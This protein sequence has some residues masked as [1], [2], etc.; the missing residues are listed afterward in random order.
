ME[1]VEDF[2]CEAK[3][4]H[5]SSY[6]IFFIFQFSSFFFTFSFSFS[7][8]FIFFVFSIFSVFFIFSLFHFFHFFIFFVFFFFS[9]FFF[10]FSFSFL[11]FFFLFF[12]FFIFFSRV[13][14]SDAFLLL[15]FRTRAE[16]SRVCMITNAVLI[17]MGALDGKELFAIEGSEKLALNS[18]TTRRSAKNA[19]E[20]LKTPS[21]RH[22][23][24][25][26]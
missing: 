12:F 11:F 24:D 6:F 10:L 9:F 18:G 20:P 1:I 7:N 4:L 3:F 25:C 13:L 8:V 22:M 19:S 23:T 26:K 17:G 21:H 16:V 14:E 2:A 5:F 15:L